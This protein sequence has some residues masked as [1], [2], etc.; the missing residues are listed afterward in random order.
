MPVSSE[1]EPWYSFDFGPIHFLEYSTEHDFSIGSAQYRFINEDLKSVNRSK[2]PWIIVGGHR[3]IYID[4][5]FARWPDGDL[6]V[7]FAL[8][9]ALEPLFYKYKVDLTWHGHHHSY[10]RTCPVYREQ[11]MGYREDGTA[12][13]PVHMV[14]GHAGAG[15]CYNIQPR[16]P[17]YFEKVIIEH[18][19]SRIFANGTRLHMEVLY[20]RD[21]RLMD[22]LT[23]QKPEDWRDA[24]NTVLAD[25]PSTLEDSRFSRASLRNGFRLGE[26]IYV[27]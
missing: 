9:Q 20:D 25:V 26:E 6:E 7:A 12:R 23:L 18:G 13:A 11:C 14:I 24:W 10:Q 17:P 27:Q 4:S 22:S 5:I 16:R 8:K 15:L 21:Q 19:Y 1:D 2:T 3:P